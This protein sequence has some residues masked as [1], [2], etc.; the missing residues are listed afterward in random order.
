MKRYE[1]THLENKI[2]AK[3]KDKEESELE[4]SDSMA[5]EAL[6]YLKTLRIKRTEDALLFLASANYV[7]KYIKIGDKK[8]LYHFKEDVF[9][10]ADILAEGK[11]PK[12][13]Y[14]FHHDKGVGRVLV[15]QIGEIQFSFHDDRK[16]DKYQNL[17]ADQNLTWREVRLQH[18][19]K[20]VYEET[21]KYVWSR[22]NDR[23]K[24]EVSDAAE[25]LIDSQK[26]F[27]RIMFSRSEVSRQH[28][29]QFATY[30]DN[31]Y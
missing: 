7:N 6:A 1:L 28:A 9:F 11:I 5:I 13:T 21:K 12:V 27:R 2:E 16:L 10:A 22:Y 17:S 19:S 29:K 8:K 4:L 25:K 3:A 26:T 20:F 23:K 18:H 15:I 14:G 30:L 31:N 24:A